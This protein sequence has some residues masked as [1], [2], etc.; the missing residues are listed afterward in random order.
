MSREQG[1]KLNQRRSRNPNRERSIL[2]LNIIILCLITLTAIGTAAFFYLQLQASNAALHEMNARLNGTD[3]QDKTLYTQEELDAQLENV[4]IIGEETGERDIKTVIQSALASGRTTLSMLRELF[5]EDVVVAN[6]G[7]Y[8]FYPVSD[9]IPHNSFHEGDYGLDEH[10]L[11]IYKGDDVN[12]SLTQGIQVSA[13]SGDI[14]WEA[15]AADHVEFAMIYVGGRNSDGEL[16]ADEAFADNIK[17]AKDAGLSVGIYYSLAARTTDE[18]QEDAEW[19]IDLLSPYDEAID[20]YAAI[21]VRTPES[22]DRTKGVSRAVWTDNL[23]IVS[24]TLKLAGYQPMLFSNLTAMMMQ[25]EP[26]A[27]AGLARWVSNVGTD[28]Y[29]PY[30]FDM[31]RYTSDSVVDGIEEPVARCVRI[32][33]PDV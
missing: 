1:Y 32:K 17:S 31:W 21:L 28:L 30:T 14:D 11:L 20:S 2:L 19:L 25:T 10:G 27:I 5:P 6:E 23:L 12:I 7:Q 18:A 4:R 26:D 8:Y 24:N 3:G 16:T 33:M 22:G 15:V 9:D 13:Q 29:Y